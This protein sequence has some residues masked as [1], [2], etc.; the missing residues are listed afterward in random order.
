MTNIIK[1]FKARGNHIQE[2]GESTS[3][4]CVIGPRD[5]RRYPCSTGLP[6][7]FRSASARVTVQSMQMSPQQSVRADRGEIIV[8]VSFTMVPGGDGS[9]ARVDFAGGGEALQ[10][11]NAV[12]ASGVLIRFSRRV[13]ASSRSSAAGEVGMFVVDLESVYSDIS[14][15][16]HAT[17]R[18]NRQ[19]AQGVVL[20]HAD[21]RVS[22]LRSVGPAKTRSYV[23]FRHAGPDIE[24]FIV[25]RGA[26]FVSTPR[27]NPVQRDENDGRQ[28]LN[29]LERTDD[30]WTTNTDLLTATGSDTTPFETDVMLLRSD[31]PHD[32]VLIPE[33]ESRCLHLLFR[34][35]TDTSK[36][37]SGKVVA[38]PVCDGR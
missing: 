21:F 33:V 2:L 7:D 24:V 29:P 5:V 13:G 8:F 36:K 3:P 25:L 4:G 12:P 38:L 16:G 31:I 15:D 26:V 20:D 11:N 34:D 27:A 35:R 1:T 30:G 23:G 22:L 18:T 14:G 10:L 28:S 32:I 6:T 19:F 37:T 17:S 9:G